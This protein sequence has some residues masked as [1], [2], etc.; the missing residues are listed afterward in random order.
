MRALPAWHEDL[1]RSCAGIDVRDARVLASLAAQV[2]RLSALFRESD[3][4]TARDAGPY[5][6]DTAART[7]YV[8][9]YTT[10][11]LLKLGVPFDDLA[12]SPRMRDRLASG[13]SILDLGCGTGTTLLGLRAWLESRAV[14]AAPVRLHASDAVADAVSFVGTLARELDRL[15]SNARIEVSTSVGDLT[16]PSA[17]DARFDL[18]VAANTIGELPRLDPAALSGILAARLAH[19]GQVL[20]IE[21]ALRATSRDLLALRDAFI[22]LGWTVYAPC[23]RQ[24][25]CPALA[26][27]RDWCHHDLPWQ[28][29]AF[30]RTIDELVGNVKLSLKFSYLIMNRHGEALS[31]CMPAEGQPFRV[32]SERFEEK[33]RTRAFLCGEPGRLPF[34]LNTRDT[35]E[36]NRAFCEIARYDAVAI[37]TFE[38][39]AH[40][41]K[42]LPSSRVRWLPLS[43]NG[44]KA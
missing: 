30:I 42:I 21:P 24:G 20:F 39:R 3:A 4:G 16:R 29:P 22:G 17:D 7:A 41:A 27:A 13:L 8:A 12:Q 11:N 40:D 38:P 34:L 31:D 14:Q 19:E 43:V 18:V 6:R 15:P 33:G 1:L 2:A 35:S 28:R 23:F 44:G 36:E 25:A 10:S 5:L 37:D 9:Y 26:D 32:V